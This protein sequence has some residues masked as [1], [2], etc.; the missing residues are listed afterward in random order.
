[1]VILQKIKVL[2]IF[3][4]FS[5]CVM[6]LSNYEVYSTE[7]TTNV[8]SNYER[9]YIMCDNQESYLHAIDIATKIIS[10]KSTIDE[11]LEEYKGFFDIAE[12]HYP[13]NGPVDRYYISHKREVEIN[14]FRDNSSGKWNS[15]YITF[16]TCS[17]V[18]KNGGTFNLDNVKKA[19]L[20]FEGVYEN[21]EMYPGEKGEKVIYKFNVARYRYKYNVIVDFKLNNKKQNEEMYPM[22]FSQVHVYIDD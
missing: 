3:L 14:F 20:S 19:Q 4:V 6:I 7:E 2:L 21:E 16:G 22:K 5:L 13:K 11:Q 15:T 9:E 18:L 12:P 8:V 10:Q 17:G 1:M